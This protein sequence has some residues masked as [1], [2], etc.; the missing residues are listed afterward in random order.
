MGV[1]KLINGRKQHSTAHSIFSSPTHITVRKQI[2]TSST[3]LLHK[4]NN[5]PALDSELLSIHSSQL[6]F[7]VWMFFIIIFLYFSLPAMD[8]LDLSGTAAAGV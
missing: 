8:S 5:L 7:Y 3:L 4:P 2:D 6:M 1:T